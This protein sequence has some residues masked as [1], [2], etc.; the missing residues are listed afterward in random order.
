M[1]PSSDRSRIL[2]LVTYGNDTSHNDGNDTLDEQVRS[3][4]TH[5]RDTDTRLGGTVRGAKA[6]KEQEEA[7]CQKQTSPAKWADG[8]TYR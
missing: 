6:F 1:R 3:E 2:R 5:R 8:F 4:D 7:H